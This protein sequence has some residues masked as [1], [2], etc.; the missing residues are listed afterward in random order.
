MLDFERAVTRFS[1]IALGGAPVTVDHAPCVVWDTIQTARFNTGNIGMTYHSKV[2]IVW[3]GTGVCQ[4]R[5]SAQS[6]TPPPASPATHSLPLQWAMNIRNLRDRRPEPGMKMTT[7]WQCHADTNTICLLSTHPSL[8]VLC[9]SSQR[10]ISVETNSSLSLSLPQPNYHSFVISA[11]RRPT[12]I[13][14]VNMQF[15]LLT[16]V[17]LF[18]AALAAPSEHGK[19][20]AEAYTGNDALITRG[21]AK[22]HV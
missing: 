5:I 7:P 4:V 20:L 2:T 3:K 17:T 11:R 13:Q 14:L 18:A 8:S 22:Y 9:S 12:Y 10:R 1:C 21:N 16:L 15:T 19:Q 6:G